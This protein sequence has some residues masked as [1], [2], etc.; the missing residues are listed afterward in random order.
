MN[1]LAM[2]GL[3]ARNNTPAIKGKPRT[4]APSTRPTGPQESVQLGAT[5]NPVSGDLARL[6]SM[7][8][9]LSSSKPV[10]ASPAPQQTPVATPTP[11]SA[12]QPSPAT[13]S[14]PAAQT[15]SAT[16]QGAEN[17]RSTLQALDMLSGSFQSVDT[18]GDGFISEDEI[19]TY[20]RQQRNAPG[21]VQQAL[22][23][24]ANAVPELMFT[25]IQQGD[26]AFFGLARE[27]L[28]AT[29]TALRNG[30]SLGQ[31][32][33]RIADEVMGDGKNIF[34]I[35]ARLNGGGNSQA[36]RAFVN[37]QRL[38]IMRRRAGGGGKG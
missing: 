27:D 8:R 5:A 17:N 24:V 22:G 32:Q 2:K 37:N 12:A 21:G 36:L 13:A 15:T 30:E 25:T 29:S 14:T 7:R 20:Q 19:R 11:R 23:N 9:T 16:N 1:L 34:S 35:V 38:R 33:E 26:D 6:Q 3:T 18:S 28:Q 10:P 4:T 31:V